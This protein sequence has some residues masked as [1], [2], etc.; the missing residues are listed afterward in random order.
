MLGGWGDQE[1]AG[2]APSQTC[3]GAARPP[4][5]PPVCV[6]TARP[7]DTW[8]RPRG[9][10]PAEPTLSS[11][12]KASPV[13]LG[14]QLLFFQQGQGWGWSGGA[15]AVSA[16][17]PRG[18][19]NQVPP[20]WLTPTASSLPPLLKEGL[21]SNPTFPGPPS[22]G[23]GAHPPLCSAP[24]PRATGQELP[25]LSH[26]AEGQS[27]GM[28]GTSGNTQRG[29]STGPQLGAGL[30]GQ[31]SPSSECRSIC[32]HGDPQRAKPHPRAAERS[33]PRSIPEPPGSPDSPLCAKHA[34]GPLRTGVAV[35]R[36]L[37]VGGSPRGRAGR[38]LHTR[39][40]TIQTLGNQIPT[41][42]HLSPPPPLRAGTQ[43]SGRGG[44]QSGPP[45][46]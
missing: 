8:I 26:G 11:P 29:S 33:I 17:P 13:C 41:K 12:Q 42:G 31:G 15:A 20:Q 16:P 32:S 21:P 40:G 39:A 6:S 28:K 34:L 2:C 36:P 19:Q 46:P 43:A 30:T 27:C 9:Q 38:P 24:K 37:L 18:W 10:A 5:T 4:P 23:S 25:G 3:R 35:A 7:R 45:P 14:P 22:S 1:G 44:T